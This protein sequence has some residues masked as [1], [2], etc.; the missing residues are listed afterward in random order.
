M[1]GAAGPRAQTRDDP[2][3]RHISEPRASTMRTHAPLGSCDGG[4]GRKRDEYGS[5][6]PASD[7]TVTVWTS[8]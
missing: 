2:R 1:C 5:M 3:V 7:E 6:S 4:S 8:G